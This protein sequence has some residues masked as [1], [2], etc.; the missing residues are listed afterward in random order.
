MKLEVAPGQLAALRGHALFAGAEPAKRL[1]STYFDTADNALHHAGVSLRVRQVNGGRV[2]TIKAE[3]KA[4]RAG[5]FERCEWEAPIEGETPDLSLPGGDLV[6]KLTGN[7]HAPELEPRFTVVIERAARVM[8]EGATRLEVTLDEGHVEAPG[9]RSPLIEVELELQEG[10]EEDLLKVARRL[11]EDVPLRLAVR[12]KSEAGYE[13][14]GDAHASAKAASVELDRKMSSAEAFTAIG[15]N[16]LLHLLRNERLVRERRAPEAV[17]QARVALRRLRA[18]MS[19]FKAQFIDLESIRLKDEMKR[20]A[21]ALGDARDLDVFEGEL[22]A[23]G[24]EPEEMEALNAAF[25]RRR[26]SAYDAAV[27]ALSDPAFVRLTFDILAWLHAGAWRETPAAQRPV[28]ELAADELT[29]RRKKLRKQGPQLHKLTPEARHQ[30]R[31]QAKKLRYGAEFFGSLAAGAK[32]RKRAEAFIGALKP[33]QDAL[34]E[35]NDV[36]AQG[37]LVRSLCE[38]AAPGAA[39][40][41]GAIAARRAREGRNLLRD[42]ENAAR[43]FAVRKLFL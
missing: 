26:E 40:A 33:V 27:A 5:L 8:E 15:A 22:H 14:I 9:L 29:R 17:H 10:R 12:A 21:G 2:Q 7:G 41:A 13:L 18:A 35:M 34:G 20:V 1:S 32:G 11:L 36:A 30:V 38:G 6:R 16:C 25:L 4:A 37:K 28:L 39:F 24:A 31:I 43:D 3:T 19:L 42:G 23:D